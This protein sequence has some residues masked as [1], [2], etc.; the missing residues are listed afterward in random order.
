MEIVLCHNNVEA[1]PHVC[2]HLSDD[3]LAETINVSDIFKDSPCSYH[4][5][6]TSI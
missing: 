4:C 1:K 6:L 3:K 2:A 5:I